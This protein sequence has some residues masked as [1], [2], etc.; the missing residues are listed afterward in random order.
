MTIFFCRKCGTALTPDLTQLPTVPEPDA[1]EARD[2]TT[3]LA[4]STVPLGHYAIETKPWGAPYVPHPSNAPAP[5]QPRGLPMAIN[6]TWLVS[7]GPSGSFV[8]HPDDAPTLLP[9]HTNN[10]GCCGPSGTQGPNQ[11]CPCGSPLATLT[12]DCQGPHELHLD[13]TRVHPY[14]NPTP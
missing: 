12:A 4:P 3:R 11:A 2:R 5:S 13:P 14:T 7:A 9:T 10:Q 6:N 8:L 1:A